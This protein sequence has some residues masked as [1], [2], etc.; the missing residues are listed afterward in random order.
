VLATFGAGFINGPPQLSF[1]L[2]EWLTVACAFVFALHI[3]LTDAVTR[4]VSPLAVTEASFVVVAAGSSAV[5]A[6]GLLLPGAPTLAS[7]AALAFERDFLVPML[8]AS[9]LATVVALTL[10]NVFQRDLDPVRAAV[11]YAIEPVWAAVIAIALGLAHA[12]AWLW[13]GG[14]ALLAGNLIAEV[15]AAKATSSTPGDA[16]R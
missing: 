16:A 13:I 9:L 2:P 10:M 14:I 4:R 11:L 7:V 1:G 8:L 12:G 6:C 15:G 3:L 5:L